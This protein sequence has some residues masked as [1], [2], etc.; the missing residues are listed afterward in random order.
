MSLSYSPDPVAWV[1]IPTDPADGWAN[2]AATQLAA[3]QGEPGSDLSHVEG[4]LTAAQ[5]GAGDA[6]ARWIYLPDLQS[7]GVV[8]DLDMV[9]LGDDVPDDIDV[10]DEASGETE[11]FSAGLVHGKRIIWVTPG[12][13]STEATDDTG[14]E[15]LQGQV[16]YVGTVRGSGYLVTM[17]SGQ[18]PIEAI[19]NSVAGCEQLFATMQP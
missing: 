10:A 18:H 17:R 3:A 16:L 4:V 6:D 13:G 15:A 2:G 14:E 11:E 5:S 7:D 8:V 12:T 9:D 19:I 1:E